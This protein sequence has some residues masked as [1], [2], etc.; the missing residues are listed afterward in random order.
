MAHLAYV[1]IDGGYLRS[2]AWDKN[3]PLYNPLEVAETIVIQHE[4][5]SWA[6]APRVLRNVRI[7]RVIYYDARPEGE[8]DSELKSYWDAVELLPDTHLGF[9]LVRGQ[10]RRQKAVDTLIAVD[11]L[12]GAFTNL[13]AVAVLISGDADFVPVVDEVRRCGIMVAV[14]AEKDTVAEDL[15]RAADRFVEIDPKAELPVMKVGDQYWKPPAGK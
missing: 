13:F 9:G 6:T 14:A 7:A 1:F 8:K 11:M 5:Q 4:V 10:P 2:I 3:R 12:V 15:M